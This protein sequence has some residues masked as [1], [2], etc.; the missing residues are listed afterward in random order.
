MLAQEEARDVLGHN[1]VG[2]EHVL[3]GLLQADGLAADVLARLGVDLATARE[4]VVAIVG[5]GRVVA[6]VG[7]GSGAA[8][9]NLP[10]TPRAKHVLELALCAS[11]AHGDG[12]VGTEHVL[13]ALLDERDGV[14]VTVLAQFGLEADAVRAAVLET[15]AAATAG[16]GLERRNQMLRTRLALVEA[17]LAACQRRTEVADAGA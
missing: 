8:N 5:R 2:T 16:P 1:H 6:I 7:G 13:L 14:A 11:M 9:E 17:L 10:F 4:R 15:M 3:L 12:E